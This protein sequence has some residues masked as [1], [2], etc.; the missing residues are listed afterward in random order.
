MDSPR[1]MYEVTILKASGMHRVTT[2]EVGN[3]SGSGTFLLGELGLR[4]VGK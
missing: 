2:S 1:G 3:G 4:A